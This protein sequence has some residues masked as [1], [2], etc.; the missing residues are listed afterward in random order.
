MAA[1][2]TTAKNMTTTITKNMTTNM[3]KNMTTTITKIYS[4]RYGYKYD[5]I[6]YCLLKIKTGNK[7]LVCT[8]SLN[9]HAFFIT[10]T[11]WPANS[12][13]QLELSHK[14]LY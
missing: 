5:Y 14:R 12:L 7:N 9:K 11:T 1:A 4:Y 13:I 8:L 6:S 3:N 10:Q 2:T